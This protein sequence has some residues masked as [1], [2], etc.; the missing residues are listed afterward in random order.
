[1]EVA[2]SNLE[3]QLEKQQVHLA[4]L[5]SENGEQRDI[6]NCIRLMHYIKLDIENEKNASSEKI[7]CKKIPPNPNTHT[8]K[9]RSKTKLSGR[10][11]KIDKVSDLDIDSK[12]ATLGNLIECCPGTRRNRHFIPLD[13]LEKIKCMIEQNP[14]NYLLPPISIPCQ[15]HFR[16][17]ANLDSVHSRCDKS[18]NI[19]IFYD[20][21]RAIGYSDKVEEFIKYLD[22]VIYSK[23]QE[24]LR[25]I[26]N[27]YNNGFYN[28]PT[29]CK[30]P[31]CEK[32]KW[33]QTIECR[34]PFKFKEDTYFLN[35]KRHYSYKF[36]C[37][38]ESFC[39]A[40]NKNH[41]DGTYCSFDDVW[42]TYDEELKE[43]YT[44]QINEGK[45]QVCPNCRHFWAKDEECD[46][47]K[48]SQCSTKF[49]FTCGD[50]ITDLGDNYLDHL[51][52]GPRIDKIEEDD[53]EGDNIHFRC[54]K[55]YIRK[56]TKHVTN[57]ENDKKLFDFVIQSL[58]CEKIYLKCAEA[59]VSKHPLDDY[60]DKEKI[61]LKVCIILGGL[62]HKKIHTVINEDKIEIKETDLD[63]IKPS[64]GISCILNHDTDMRFNKV[65]FEL[66]KSFS[67]EIVL[68]N[69]IL[70]L[71]RSV[72]IE[73]ES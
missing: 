67:L 70:D 22:N 46:K 53:I 59:L 30:C 11:S 31:K 10:M 18:L 43:T 54:C 55:T 23:E 60:S 45:G 21:L 14:Y 5:R 58:L 47:V 61:F 50:D 8:G 40:C 26:V 25:A 41:A 38:G 63:R 2:K 17:P 71:I 57:I 3:I 16:C 7:V 62:Y 65:T 69:D 33:L 73:N 44:Q 27:E 42:D 12:T 6:Q 37:C 52:S 39:A 29:I 48:C 28:Y 64:Q 1:M 66:M 49:C 56:A 20:R 51:I 35:A 13:D 15:W 19:N 9:K 68:H 34:K 32:L 72:L 36:S 24:I 4:K